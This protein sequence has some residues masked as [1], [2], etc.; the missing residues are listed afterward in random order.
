VITTDNQTTIEP[1][2]EADALA[3]AAD[4]FL[5]PPDQRGQPDVRQEQLRQ[6]WKAYVGAP[7]TSPEKR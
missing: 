2:N 6:A 1:Q 3:T 5:L 7:V 4:L